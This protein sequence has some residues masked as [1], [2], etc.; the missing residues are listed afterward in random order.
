MRRFPLPTTPEGKARLAVRLREVAP[1]LQADF[2]F[3]QC[4]FEDARWTRLTIGEVEMGEPP[5]DPSKVFAIPAGIGSWEVAEAARIAR[6]K[7]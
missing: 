5:P 1:D 4:E 2:E 6:K 7:R 3:W